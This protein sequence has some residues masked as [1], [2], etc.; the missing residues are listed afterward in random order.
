MPDRPQTGSS[1]WRRRPPARATRLAATT[2]C[3][4][5][6]PFAVPGGYFSRNNF[7]LYGM[8]GNAAEWM[9]DC[10]NASHHGAPRDGRV[11]TSGDCTKRLVRGSSWASTPAT[12]RSAARQ[13]QGHA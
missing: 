1:Q 8:L 9:Q 5:G 4:D 10:W 11:R 2:N 12:I 3:K 6:D 7:S 13:A